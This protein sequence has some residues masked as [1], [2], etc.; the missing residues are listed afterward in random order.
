MTKKKQ[1]T[2]TVP[3]ALQKLKARLGDTKPEKGNVK[4]EK[5]PKSAETPK[6]A[7]KMSLVFF[8]KDGM[9]IKRFDVAKDDFEKLLFVCKAR[10]GD[11]DRPWLTVLHVERTL[12]GCR[13]V[14]TDG[15]R[16]HVAVSGLKIASGDYYPYV[17]KD[18]VSLGS[19]VKDV[20]F[21]N[22]M[23][24]LP[25]KPRKKGYLDLTNTGF[26][27]DAKQTERLSQAFTGFVKK[28]GATVNLR[29]IED[30]PKTDWTVY[31]KKEKDK[32]LVFK[33]TDDPEG[34]F[35]VMMPLPKVA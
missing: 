28:I 30:L 34:A 5:L 16:L 25:E 21:P 20:A 23:R 13:L 2:D 27:K 1:N 10:S 26:G 31:G 11:K 6:A 35:A 33:K 19:P 12:A 32:P 18:V 15:R 9:T 8:P 22:W 7:S 4:E 24:V 17:T 29:F 3:T 14:A